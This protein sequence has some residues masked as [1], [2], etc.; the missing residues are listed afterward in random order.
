M[1]KLEGAGL[2]NV[3]LDGGVTV[4]GVGDEQTVSYSNLDGLYKE[5]A[6]AISLRCDA[7]TGPELRFL[8]KRLGMSQADVATLGGKTEQVVGKWEKGLLPVPKAEAQLLRLSVLSR[9]GSKEEISRVVSQLTN[10][11]AR[12][13][14]YPYVM[15]FSDGTW[16]QDEQAA[17]EMSGVRSAANQTVVAIELTAYPEF[18]AVLPSTAPNNQLSVFFPGEGALIDV[19][20]NM[21]SLG[22]GVQHMVFGG[23]RPGLSNLAR[24]STVGTSHQSVT[25]FQITK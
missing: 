16:K 20:V 17:I 3:Y 1:H 14:Q 10:G 5:I 18:L 21:R 9:F 6:R 4:E 19:V 8:R 22:R 25:P 2:P 7:L 24:L 15:K 11:S 23:V 12:G 13:D